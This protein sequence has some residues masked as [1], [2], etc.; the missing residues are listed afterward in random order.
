MLTAQGWAQDKDHNFD[1]AKNLD[2]LN[3]IYKQLDMMYVDTLKAN[4]VIGNGINAMLR[5]LDPYTEYYP[6]E[7][8]K[9]LTFL[10]TGT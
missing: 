4:E 5:S 10:R 1:V 7:K 6:E 9:E 2:V 8:L 3:V